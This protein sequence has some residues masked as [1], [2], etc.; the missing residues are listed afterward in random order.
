MHSGRST[1]AQGGFLASENTYLSVLKPPAMRKL[2]CLFFLFLWGI[3]LSS[4]Q[5]P[6][7]VTPTQNSKLETQNSVRAVV[8]GISDYQD[9]AIPDLRFADR[10]AEAFANFLR[11]PAGG[12]LDVD[13]LKL[14]TNEQATGAQLAKTLD[15]LIEV[16]QEGDQVIIYFSGHGDVE[17]KRISQPGYLLGWDAPSRVYSAGGA[18]NVRDFQ[19]IISTLSVINKAKVV[20]ITDACHSG[21]LSGNEING[22]QLTGQNL[23]RQFANE[24]KILSCQ[25][26][27]YS[28]EGEQWG[29]GRGAFSYH[30]VDALY[31]LADANNDLSVN[32]KEVGRY[33]E[34]HVTAE[35][36]PVN[37]N[38]KVIGSPTERLAAVDAKLL[39][40][41]R[42]GKTSQMQMLSP[43]DM[44]GMEDEVLAGV[45]TSVRELYQLFIQA[46][47]EKVFLEPAD[48][49]ADAY[50]GKL[51]AEAGMARLHSTMTRNYAAALQDDAQ[52]VLNIMLK[53]GLTS[54][55]LSAA[56]AAH[57]YRNYPA[58]LDRAAELLGSGH[59]MYAALKARKH[60]FEGTLQTEKAEKKKQFF[61]ALHWQPD[62]PH[63]YAALIE[64][65]PVEQTDSAEHY[66]ARAMQI[67]PAW[68]RPYISLSNFYQRAKQPG[69]AEDMLNRASQVDSNSIL[70]WYAKANYYQRQKKYTASEHWYLKAIT[71]SGEDICFPCAHHDLGIVYFASQRYVEAELQFK[72][73]IQLDSTLIRAYNFLGR[74]YT[75]AGRFTEAEQQFKK[76]IQLDSTQAI[77]YNNLGVV[78]LSTGRL[79]EAEQQFKKTIQLDSTIVEAYNNLGIIYRNTLHN[80]EAEQQYKKAIQVDSTYTKAY[81]NLGVL[82]GETQRYAEAEQQFKKSSQL[83]STNYVV[84]YNLTCLQSRQNQMEQAYETLEKALKNGYSEYERMHDDPDLAPLRSMPEWAALMKKY[85]PEKVKD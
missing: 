41:L 65:Y 45:D 80:A 12:S 2:S 61:Q 35:V 5:Q 59:Y 17:A 74:V 66:A 23:A 27:E 43:V 50:Y 33:L 79:A 44:R 46:L 16:T 11:S 81:N 60:Y 9:P 14:L 69:K 15:W 34:D 85:F 76:T 28:I 63:A 78:Y 68:V 32:L 53:S 26:D 13:H 71:G 55:I 4:A 30:L 56:K 57:L 62:M 84:F 7:G 19:D 10:D 39:A 22:A 73:A 20:V 49:C 38:P 3:S 8:V 67:V 70:V 18:M 77:A 52:Q 36:A 25:P 24:V 21:K 29:G 1:P 58:Y 42:S 82:Y 72:K 83:D 75:N 51:M 48:A 47:K 40:D 31:G 37:Q 6:K 64:Q 54:E